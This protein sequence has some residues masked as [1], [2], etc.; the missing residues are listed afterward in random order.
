MRR[1][2]QPPSSWFGVDEAVLLVALALIVVGLWSRIGWLALTIPG[3]VLLWM[4]LPPRQAFVMR[5]EARESA[6]PRKGT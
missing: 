5:S 6:S 3:V 4:A 2:E 1:S